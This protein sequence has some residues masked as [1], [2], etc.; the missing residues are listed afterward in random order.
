MIITKHSSF[1]SSVKVENSSITRFF[2]LMPENSLEFST[3]EIPEPII[4]PQTLE[5]EQIL[6]DNENRFRSF[7]SSAMGSKNVIG[8]IQDLNDRK[9][10][11]DAE[12]VIPT[13]FYWKGA[14]GNPSEYKNYTL[15]I[16]IETENIDLTK[17]TI[18][19]AG[20][21]FVNGTQTVFTIASP[22]Y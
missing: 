5:Q 22:N 16:F 15:R 7:I 1:R 18:L 17:F 4:P 2:Y 14:Y 13:A 21:D 3:Y 12:I 19:L 20:S 9:Y 10:I 11:G 8:V 6:A